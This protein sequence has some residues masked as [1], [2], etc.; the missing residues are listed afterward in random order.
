M[1]VLLT[2]SAGFIGF[3][4]AR[5]LLA[6]GDTVIG[7]DNFNP[8]YDATLKE[9]RNAILEKSPNFHLIRGNLENLSELQ[10]AYTI[11]K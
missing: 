4:T 11:L 9:K 6:R 2:G 1:H 8:Y 7:F 3:H 10:P 5:A